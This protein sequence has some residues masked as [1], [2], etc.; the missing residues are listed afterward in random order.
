MCSDGGGS[1]TLSF[2]LRVA[3]SLSLSMSL[4]VFL[5][6]SLSLSLSFFLSLSLSLSVSVSVCLRGSVKRDNESGGEIQA[7]QDKADLFQ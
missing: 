3:L 1:E 7:R 5:S 6:L 2:C 4:S